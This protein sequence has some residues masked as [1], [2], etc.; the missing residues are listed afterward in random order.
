MVKK[1][2]KQRPKNVIDQA[3]AEGDLAAIELVAHENRIQEAVKFKIQEQF[4][5]IPWD[6]YVNTVLSK[7]IEAAVSRYLDQHFD[8]DSAAWEEVMKEVARKAALCFS[9][10]YDVSVVLKPKK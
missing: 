5:R 9:A 7:Q 8:P 2:V 6:A 3:I 10:T 4:S 1:K